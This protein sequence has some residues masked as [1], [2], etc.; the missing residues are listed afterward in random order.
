MT[1]LPKPLDFWEFIY[2]RQEVWHNRYIK[3]LPR[4]WTKD[5]ILDRFKFCEVY[6]ENDRCTKYLIKR[7]ID[8]PA[9]SNKQKV[10]A[11]LVF[12]VFNI[13][14]FFDNYFK[15]VPSVELFDAEV[16]IKELDLAKAKGLNLFNDA[17]TITQLK[18]DK[19]A[20]KD[21]H[22][23][24]LL[25]LQ[26]IA[27]DWEHLFYRGIEPAET[28]EDIFNVIRNCK[29]F[30]SFL[31]GQCLTDISYIKGFK[32]DVDFDEWYPVGPGAVGG[33]D[34]FCALEVEDYEIACKSV[35]KIQEQMFRKLYQETGKDWFNVKYK[36]PY[37]TGDYLSLNNIQSCFCEWRKYLNYINETG[38]TKYYKG[39]SHGLSSK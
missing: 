17:Y 31:A 10:F 34:A 2:N 39:E 38:R 23:Q 27:K 29:F 36:T 32:G 30:G 16:R 22:V 3:Q 9:L 8:N 20:R 18:F 12:R 13:D 4:P 14:G 6:R 15:E 1:C 11:I 28:A 24:H 35:W 21:K 26:N 37:R 19:Y 33:L 7:V 25:N 5:T